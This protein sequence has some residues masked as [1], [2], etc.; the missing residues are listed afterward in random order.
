MKTAK[1]LAAVALFLSAGAPVQ[2]GIL[3]EIWFSAAERSA[4]TSPLRDWEIALGSA[5]CQLGWERE[6]GASGWLYDI[7]LVDKGKY[8][9]LSHSDRY[10]GALN[11]HQQSEALAFGKNLRLGIALAGSE[12]E[13]WQ[14]MGVVEAD[15]QREWITLALSFMTDGRDLRWSV[16]GGPFFNLSDRL[17]LRWKIDHWGD[18]NADYGGSKIQLIYKF[19]KGDI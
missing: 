18:E 13:N 15:F 6:E 12:W 14:V 7:I 1:I 10:R 19:D 4:K 17:T 9:R 2:S 5:E 3:S 11:V 8:Y 16:S